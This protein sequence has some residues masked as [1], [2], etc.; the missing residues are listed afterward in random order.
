MVLWNRAALLRSCDTVIRQPGGETPDPQTSRLGG[1]R[2]D[3]NAERDGAITRSR[4]LPSIR[5]GA[6]QTGAC[7]LRLATSQG[8]PATPRLPDE[9]VHGQVDGTTIRA[10]LKREASSRSGEANCWAAGGASDSSGCCTPTLV[11]RC[12]RRRITRAAATTTTMETAA[13]RFKVG[14]QRQ[15]G[16]PPPL[17]GASSAGSAGGSGDMVPGS[18][19]KRKL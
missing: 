10:A 15:G 7:D 12:A 3:N 2:W 18:G 5:R 13:P 16:R 17:P 1:L 19:A 9:N 6:Q 14:T 8:G 4:L 11:L